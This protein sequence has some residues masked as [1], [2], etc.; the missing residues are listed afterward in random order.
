VLSV[1][2]KQY[3]EGDI[4]AIMQVFVFPPSESRSNLV[5]LLSLKQI[6]R[7]T[8]SHLYQLF[9]KIKLNQDNA[10]TYMGHVQSAQLEH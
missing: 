9:A 7:V 1:S 3:T 5:S 6:D 2:S 8:I 10:L 4:V